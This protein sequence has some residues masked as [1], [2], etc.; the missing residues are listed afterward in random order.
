MPRDKANFVISLRDN[1]DATCTAAVEHACI[2]EN[3]ATVFVSFPREACPQL[4]FLQQVELRMTGDGLDAPLITR[5]RV[6]F[7]GLTLQSRDFEFQ[8]GYE[9]RV[10]LA[11]ALNRRSAVRVCPAAEEPIDLVIRTGDGKEIRPVVNDISITGA[12]V[13]LTQ[14]E[15]LSLADHWQAEVVLRLPTE[16]EELELSVNISY[17]RLRGSA[18]LYG[19]EFD[20]DHSHVFGFQQQSLQRYVMQR[21]VE[22]LGRLKKWKTG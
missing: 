18:I 4:D 16:A 21:Q 22:L 3:G 5:G 1:S 6:V 10:L 9:A 7:S 2:A 17:R 11:P 14:E 13:L 20:P 8:L 12:G 19:I 15:E